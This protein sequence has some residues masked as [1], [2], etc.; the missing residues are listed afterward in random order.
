[1]AGAGKTAVLRCTL[2]NASQG[3]PLK[4]GLDLGYAGN[5]SVS[6]VLAVLGSAVDEDVTDNTVSADLPPRQE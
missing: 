6:A 2:P 3:D 4:L 1:M 5:G